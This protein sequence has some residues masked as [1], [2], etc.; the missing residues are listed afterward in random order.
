MRSSLPQLF[1]CLTHGVYVVGV[2]AD[3]VVNAF[4]AALI[5]Q[6][7]FDPPMVALSVNPHHRSYQILKR[8]QGF[9]V[10]VLSHERIDLAMHFGQPAEVDK[11]STVPWSR[12]G[13]GM[14]ILD[15]ALAWFD[16]HVVGE[17]TAG[18]HVVVTAMVVD[19][20]VRHEAAV[21]MNYRDTG[22]MDGSAALF[23]S[24]FPEP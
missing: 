10:N 22:S 23:P 24:D 13:A 4:T 19:G 16:C 7:S 1:S 14:P 8:S 20:A 18:D 3:A 21:P 5:M 11:L 2:S 9:S 12:S 17:L 6:V 15:D